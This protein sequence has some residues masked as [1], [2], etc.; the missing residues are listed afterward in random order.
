MLFLDITLYLTLLS[1]LLDVR[2]L[3]FLPQGCFPKEADLGVDPPLSG[4]HLILF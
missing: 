1:S 3:Y 4:L 2:L